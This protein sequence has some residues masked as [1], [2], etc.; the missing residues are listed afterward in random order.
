[1]RNSL[2][3]RS[4]HMNTPLLGR[5]L[6]DE[7]MEQVNASAGQ[8]QVNWGGF[9]GVF[10][11]HVKSGRQIHKEAVNCVQKTRNQLFTIRSDSKHNKHKSMRLQTLASE[12]ACIWRRNSAK[13][14]GHSVDAAWTLPRRQIHSNQHAETGQN[15]KILKRTINLPRRQRPT[16]PPTEA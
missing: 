15:K 5:K 10:V 14:T 3:T 11:G 16:S 7:L 12:R 4:A 6:K 8:A 9:W 1:M 13:K 2:A